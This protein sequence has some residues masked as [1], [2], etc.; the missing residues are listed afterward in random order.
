M[1]NKR[2]RKK[3]PGSKPQVSDTNPASRLEDKLTGIQEALTDLC[4]QRVEMA[5]QIDEDLGG[6]TPEERAVM[7]GKFD[8]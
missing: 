8:K 3:Q 6:Y 4:A 2:N 7:L 5:R 1:K